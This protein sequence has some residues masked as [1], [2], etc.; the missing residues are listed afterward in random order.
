MAYEKLSGFCKNFKSV[1]IDENMPLFSALSKFLFTTIKP[2]IDFSKFKNPFDLLR[3]S[4]IFIL[5]KI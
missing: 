4:N 1:K 3:E 2:K 5:N